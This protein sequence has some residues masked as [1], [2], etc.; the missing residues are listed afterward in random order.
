MSM[1]ASF[2]LSPVTNRRPDV[3]K[4]KEKLS[5]FLDSDVT[6]FEAA[7]IVQFPG[8]NRLAL[9]LKANNYNNDSNNT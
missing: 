5:L 9:Y 6:V 1:E 7:L 8:F 2:G 3:S 4:G